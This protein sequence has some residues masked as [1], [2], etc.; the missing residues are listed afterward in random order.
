MTDKKDKSTGEK[1]PV[2][3]ILAEYSD[4]A[5]LIEASKK[6]RDAGFQKWDTYTPF[7]VH[8]IDP[9]MGIKPTILPWIVLGAGLTGLAAGVL[10]QWWTNAIDYPWITSGKPMWS[11]PANIPIAFE[12]TILFSA[13]TTL[14]GMLALNKLPHP[15]HPLDLK[16]RFERATDDKFFLLVEA[17]DPKYDAEEVTAL[18]EPHADLVE[19]LLD[20]DQTPSELPR[21]LIYGLVILTSLAIVPFA[22]AAHARESKSRTTRIH[23]IP[24][25]DAQ[26][27]YKSQRPNPFFEDGRSAR[28]YVDGTVARGHLQED[29]HFYRGKEGDAWA[30]TFPNQVDLSDAT[31]Q[32]GREQ[33]DVFCAPCHGYQGRGNG[34][35]TRRADSIGAGSDGWVP[36]SDVTDPVLE[37]QP[38][39]QLYN[40]IA[41]GVRNMPAYG[42]QIEPQDRW[43]IVMYMRAL[44][45][46]RNATTKDLT[47]SEIASLK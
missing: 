11:L 44:Q 23:I 7:P 13:L 43:A 31:M 26:T 28:S 1:R 33:F 20:D 15:S 9:A 18:L 37:K 25:M 10:L 35:V 6:V 45:R 46:S 2:F 8:G 30:R 47:E 5:V 42:S 4:P 24:D 16:E 34:M 17:S 27:K 32:R 38:V 29:D 14:G 39:G 12:L 40:S 19:P 36:P 22:L 41:N 21:G 3:G